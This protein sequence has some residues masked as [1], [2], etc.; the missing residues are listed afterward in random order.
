M[1]KNLVPMT[2]FIFLSRWSY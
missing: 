2:W 1:I